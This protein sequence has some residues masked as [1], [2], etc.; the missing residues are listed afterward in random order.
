[1]WFWTYKDDVCSFDDENVWQHVR[2]KTNEKHTRTHARGPTHACA[3][4][5]AR[6][7]PHARHT[8]THTRARAHTH[9]CTHTR[10][11]RGR[12]RK[13]EIL[14]GPIP[15]G[16]LWRSSRWLT[17]PW[18]LYNRAFSL[19]SRRHQQHER[20][21]EAGGDAAGGTD[22]AS[23]VHPRA[24]LWRHQ[25]QRQ[26]RQMTALTSHDVRP[27]THPR[28]DVLPST[29]LT[30]PPIPR[31]VRRTAD[32]LDNPLDWRPW[33]MCGC[34]SDEYGCGHCVLD[35]RLWILLQL[36]Q[37]GRQECLERVLWR[38]WNIFLGCLWR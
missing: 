37:S 31:H 13:R 2:S 18:W 17:T 10:I 4:T 33:I 27:P 28:S 6:T 22:Q 5:H 12:E 11:Y 7:H 34:A 26:L 14:H 21:A 23:P 1:M 29:P 24:H 30:L 32:D 8:R 15:Q 38:G 16:K 19:P 3:R 25:D 9:A 35:W 20:A 36:E